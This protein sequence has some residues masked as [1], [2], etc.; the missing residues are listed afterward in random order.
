MRKPS[1]LGFP[2]VIWWLVHTESQSWAFPF[3][4]PCVACVHVTTA[5][6]IWIMEPPP[7]QCLAC[8]GSYGNNHLQPIW[9]NL[10]LVFS[11][12]PI[13]HWIAFIIPHHLTVS[14]S[15]FIGNYFCLRQAVWEI[16]SFPKFLHYGSAGNSLEK[17]TYG[18]PSRLKE[19]EMVVG[20]VM[21]T[22]RS[23]R[24]CRQVRENPKKSAQKESSFLIARTLWTLYLLLNWAWL[25]S[26]AS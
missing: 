20:W 16:I 26:H 11:C 21:S 2:G 1:R 8:L 19:D 5:V 3:I 6:A 18:F 9:K 17:W 10:L 7:F 14:M 25:S 4:L 12:H 24:P 13:S 23:G 22:Q 15:L